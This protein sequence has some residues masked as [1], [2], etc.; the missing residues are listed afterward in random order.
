MYH[1]AEPRITVFQGTGQLYYVPWL[2]YKVTKS[3]FINSLS[4]W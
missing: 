2:Y 4:G 3:Q 1:L